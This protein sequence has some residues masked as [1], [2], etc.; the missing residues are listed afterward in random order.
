[1]MWS[2]TKSIVLWAIAILL[3]AAVAWFDHDDDTAQPA[4]TT[5]KQSAPR[6][7]GSEKP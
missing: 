7:A 3:I 4:K 2:K 6:D 5:V 1:V